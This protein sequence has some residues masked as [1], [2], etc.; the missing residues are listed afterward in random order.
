[1]KNYTFSASGNYTVTLEVEDN[2]GAVAS[3][4]HSISV[5][6]PVPASI[7]L[8]VTAY[9]QRGSRRAILSWSG[10]TGP[11]VSIFKDGQL[12]SNVLNTGEFTDHD[13]P[14]KAVSITY[15]VCETDLS[16]CSGESVANF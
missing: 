2:L 11:L 16:V 3:Y 6:E 8:A 12:F 5:V 7:E 4:S 10:A 9:R 14:L 15:Q 13:I 1:M